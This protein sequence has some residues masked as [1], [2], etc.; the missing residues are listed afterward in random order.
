MLDAQAE[1]VH[2]VEVRALGRL[3]AL[4]SVSRE[5]SWTGNQQFHKVLTDYVAAAARGVRTGDSDGDLALVPGPGKAAWGRTVD[6]R[7]GRVCARIP[8]QRPILPLHEEVTRL[9]LSAWPPRI[10]WSEVAI[11]LCCGLSLLHAGAVARCTFVRCSWSTGPPAGIPP[12]LHAI[13]P[14]PSVTSLAVLGN[15]VKGAARGTGAKPPHP[16]SRWQM[17]EASADPENVVLEQC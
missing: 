10:K 2:A 15:G 12:S 11:C 6:M 13:C 5:E 4:T 9:E 3:A 8:F 7:T 1:G 17:G 14:Q 16:G